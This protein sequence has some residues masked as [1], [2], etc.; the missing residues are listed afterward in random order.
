MY[1]NITKLR[2]RHLPAKMLI[3][4]EMVNPVAWDLAT[5]LI[6]YVKGKALN[7]CMKHKK[8]NVPKKE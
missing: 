7:P 4:M 6:K 1:I 3:K 8:K 2:V 5:K